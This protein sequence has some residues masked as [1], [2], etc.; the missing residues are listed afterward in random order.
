MILLATLLQF[1]AVQLY[2]A[3]GKTTATV[4]IYPSEAQHRAQRAE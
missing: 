4:L 1:H 2:C 3:D